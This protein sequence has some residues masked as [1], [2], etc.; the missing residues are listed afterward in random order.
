[1]NNLKPEYMFV[2]FF[3]DTHTAILVQN[4]KFGRVFKL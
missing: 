1:M 3:S 2:G 4:G